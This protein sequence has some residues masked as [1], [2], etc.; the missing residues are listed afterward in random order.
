MIKTKKKINKLSKKII[1]RGGGKYKQKLI[2]GWSKVKSTF[3]RKPKPQMSIE[4][5]AKK[6]YNTK[7]G[8][9]T[10]QHYS[11]LLVNA[12]NKSVGV[13]RL[14]NKPLPL[15]L[16]TETYQNRLNAARARHKSMNQTKQ[17]TQ[18][19]QQILSKPIKP[20]S[21][22]NIERANKKDMISQYL[23]IMATQEAVSNKNQPTQNEVMKVLK[24]KA[25]MYNRNLTKGTMTINNLTKSANKELIRSKLADILANDGINFKKKAKN[26][27][28]IGRRVDRITNIS[29]LANKEMLMGK[30]GNTNGKAIFDIASKNPDYA[31]EI[32]SKIKKFKEMTPE[33]IKQ[34]IKDYINPKT[35]TSNV[36]RIYEE[37]T[38]SNL[39]DT[40]TYAKL[41]FQKPKTSTTR[42]TPQPQQNSTTYAKIDYSPPE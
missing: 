19:T 35:N 37:I 14:V 26:G 8:K 34:Q 31:M 11:R 22:T 28:G 36:K 38:T 33:D 10:R 21:N 24:T 4:S 30:F 17:P 25:T 18:P 39:G 15:P 5:L 32:I 20:M 6:F 23:S 42:T 3:S 9:L 12:V 16:Y 13:N 40:T 7:Q 29:N 1:A 41:D 2:N 27:K